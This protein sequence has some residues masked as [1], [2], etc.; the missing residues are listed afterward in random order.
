M[1]PQSASIASRTPMILRLGNPRKPPRDPPQCGMS[2]VDEPVH[3]PCAARLGQR[4]Q[5]ARGIQSYDAT[6]DEAKQQPRRLVL[7]YAVMMVKCVIGL[8]HCEVGDQSSAPL[9]ER[10]L[11]PSLR[12]LMLLLRK[13]RQEA[14]DDGGIKPDERHGP[15]PLRS[16]CR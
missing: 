2:R 14:N 12:D 13:T 10:A 7:R 1:R 3:H 8:G 5:R 15:W 4:R 16:I 6:G 9:V 11:E